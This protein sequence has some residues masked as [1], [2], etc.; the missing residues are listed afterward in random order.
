MVSLAEVWKVERPRRVPFF[1]TGNKR[2][3]MN[4]NKG[5]MMR[6]KMQQGLGIG[7]W[8]RSQC[9]CARHLLSHHAPTGA[10]YFVDTK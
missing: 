9:K 1:T 6:S 8:D 2:M 3:K 5:D 10:W 7:D 4:M